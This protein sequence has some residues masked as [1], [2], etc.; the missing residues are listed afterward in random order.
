MIQPSS[1]HG[2][3]LTSRE[4][5][6]SFEN[7]LTSA[8]EEIVLVSPFIGHHIFATTLAMIPP[9]VS[10]TLITRWDPR[11]IAKGLNDLRIWEWLQ[12]RGNS[13]LRLRWDL[14][15]KYYRG[16][17]NVILGSGNLTKAGLNFRGRGNSEIMMY[18]SIEFDGVRDFERNLISSSAIPTEELYRE[19]SADVERIRLE[20]P[21]VP[22]RQPAARD[23]LAIE[24]D[25]AWK[26]ACEMPDILFEVYEH[27]TDAIDNVSRD[28][29]L[30]DLDYIQAP[31]GLTKD[32][33]KTFVRNVLAQSPLFPKV[34]AEVRAGR[35]ISIDAGRQLVS[36]TFGG[37]S[38]SEAA[39]IWSA[40]RRWLAHFYPT[41]FQIRHL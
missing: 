27:R 31:E 6:R 9:A 38:E 11:E 29:A 18:S 34:L 1:P 14:H 16:D 25:G 13:Q 19:M 10:V 21:Q 5:Y 24:V 33:F 8:V 39:D 17:F 40:S 7:L 35:P 32:E 23:I 20:E 22:I 4:V 30:D 2:R 36:A 15:A 37:V 28:I 26:P 12:E 3:I 41:D